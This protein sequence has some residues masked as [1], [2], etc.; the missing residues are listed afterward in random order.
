MI[1]GVIQTCENVYHILP[2][3][4]HVP[5]AR[6]LGQLDFLWW[7]GTFMGPQNGTCFV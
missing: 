5:R 7:R 3:T 2:C 6:A 4:I 1:F